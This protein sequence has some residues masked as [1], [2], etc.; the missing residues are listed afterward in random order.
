MCELFGLCSHQRKNVKPYLREFFSHSVRHPNGWGLATFDG[1]RTNIRTEMIAAVNSTILPGIL[2]ALPDSRLLFAHIR[3]ATIGG[4]RPENCHPFSE[5]D[6][7]GRTWT[8]M[9]NGTIFNGT[10]L[11]PFRSRQ[12][13]DTDSERI[14]LYLIG[15][16][17]EQMQNRSEALCAEERFQA[18]NFMVKELSYRNKL[19]LLL[20]DGSRMY[21]HVNMR[22]TLF[23]RQ[24][25]KAALFSTTPLTQEGWEPLPLN[26]LI[27]YE[28]GQLVCCGQ[29]HLNEYIDIMGRVTLDYHL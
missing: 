5:K 20:F 14:L 13:G 27:A 19:N 7:S 10:E 8:L 2:Q 26:T 12:K 28:D 23:V 22:D 25:E 6:A 17:N 29:R 9:H 1:G 11:L 18:V 16:L 15:L 21:V 24:E 3:R 4:V